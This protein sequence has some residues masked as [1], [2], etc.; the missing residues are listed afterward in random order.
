MCSKTNIV[1]LILNL[2]TEPFQIILDILKETFNTGF[3][4]F[5]VAL[6]IR[7]HKQK[8]FHNSYRCHLQWITAKSSY[9]VGLSSEETKVEKVYR[10]K[11][12]D[13]IRVE[14]PWREKTSPVSRGISILIE[15]KILTI[16][17]KDCIYQ[18]DWYDGDPNVLVYGSLFNFINQFKLHWSPIVYVH[19]DCFFFKEMDFSRLHARE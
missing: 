11:F 18:S 9:V 8:A 5:I 19:S 10:G 6:S 4:I 2:G 16:Y 14:C 15:R 13:T 3:L 1:W 7:A 12:T 17:I